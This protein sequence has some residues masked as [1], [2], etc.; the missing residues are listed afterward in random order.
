MKFFCFFLIIFFAFTI[1]AQTF[2]R[3]FPLA[4]NSLVQITNLYGR[5]HL[6]AEEVKKSDESE[7]K[8][9]V[10][11]AFL[12]A[13]NTKESDLKIVSE[14]KRLEIIAEPSDKNSRIDL[15]LKIP[16]HLKVKVET[17]DG[18][19]RIEGNIESAEVKTETGTIA[20]NVPLDDLKYDFVWTE[21]RPRFLSDVKLEDANEK[22]AGK[23]VI[24]GKLGDSEKEREKRRKGE[25][26]KGRK[27]KEEENK[28]VE[29]PEITGSE[30]PTKTK[31]QKPK[32]KSQKPKSVKLNFTTARG[33]V[34]LNVNPNEVPSD[35]RE[36]PLTEAA[37]AIVR[38][39]DSLLTEAIRRA[40]PKY[41]GDY[42][43]T[44]PPR[45]SFPILSENKDKQTTVNS[46]IKRVLARVTDI[47]NRAIANLKKED[48][49]VTESNE[50]R[51]I[52]SV[53]PTTAP[54][55]LVLLLDV[56]G[57]VDNYV[58]FI[59]K[60]ARNF[61]N[62][63][64]PNDKIAIII[65]NED[66]KTLSTFTTDKGVLSESL[67]TFDAGGGTS[68]YDALAYTL[69]ETLRPLKGERTA[70]VVLSDGDDNR[71]FLPF[72]SLLGSIQESG[73][74]IYPLYV[75]SGLIAA[76][77]N[78]Q[79]DS[80][81][82]PLRS[83]YMDLTSKAESEGE[84]LAEV[85]GGVYYPIS[86][87]GDL[88]RAY[89]D[90]VVQLRTAYSIT[91]RSDVSE[92]RDNRASPR[93]R[94]KVKRENSFVRLGSVVEVAPKEISDVQKGNFP[95][96][97][98][99]AKKI[100]A[101]ENTE[102]N[103]Y[104]L[105]NFATWR[106]TSFSSFIDQTPEIS[107]EIDK[108]NYKQFVND[109]LRESQLENFD[110]NK[111]TGA[112]ILNNGQEKIAVSRWISPKRTR[113]YPYERVYDTLAFA[114]RKVTIIPVVKDEG[115]GG[116]RDFL[117]WDTVSLLSLLDV[118]VVLAYYD[119]AEK[120]T[121]RADQITAQ[122]FDKNY[123]TARL[124]EVFNFKGTAREW[125][126]RE[127]KQLKNVFEKA[128][129]AYAEISKN[130]KTYLH[131]DTALIEIIKYAET[132]QKFI[133][134]SRQKSQNAQ[135]REFQTLQ[136]KEA[137]SSDTKGKVTITNAL[138]GKY[139]FTVDETRIEPKTVYLIEAKHSVRSKFP[140]RNDIKDGLVKMMIYTN[141]RNVKVGAK[142]L[143]YKVQIRL[144]SSK[145]AGS[146]TS[147]MSD[148][149]LIK[150]CSDNLIDFANKEFLKKLFQEARENKFTIILEHAEVTK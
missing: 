66:V 47:N 85:S 109:T 140:S 29:E 100:F 23:F 32:T 16:A 46:P 98:E 132:P 104:L 56:S 136:P 124:N 14:N 69:A 12:T 28:K 40:S 105:A 122:K 94:V 83:R 51:E 50:S 67:D 90:I 10:G 76:T 9:E 144:T 127:T 37:K 91:F 145:L 93:L 137:L 117:Q 33:I 71:S 106:E 7:E 78:N 38:S 6:V 54:F 135:R 31:S 60:T 115:L 99:D 143:D 95:P 70:I 45:K 89:D 119:S 73:A 72:D 149:I 121:K 107:G 81:V 44:L 102:R 55:N 120:N 147:G 114:G 113:S 80:T 146:I 59:R 19:V 5:V 1:R 57:S 128:K 96:R 48:F 41:F 84:K 24:N 138:F 97:R 92:I 79:A 42:A 27:E 26:E 88:Q 110:I 30:Q 3:D 34:L 11:K 118:Q 74:L 75:P 116:E 82:D 20:V 25:E 134:F 112:F 111:A 150:F 77:A 129:L 63:V 101:T 17:K 148:E 8:I 15:T 18:E 133:E 64:S 65:F 35:L 39:G 123:I 139:F 62:T 130:T 61:V 126:E 68:Y 52:L 125:N 141:L 58:D 13:E 22:A 43:A 21:S 131:D 87:L 4:E 86:Q 108:I 2:R 49:E 53:E 36:R 103:Q 142:P